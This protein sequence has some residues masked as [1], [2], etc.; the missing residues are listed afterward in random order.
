MECELVYIFPYR[1]FGR[2]GDIS[3]FGERYGSFQEANADGW[4]DRQIWSIV[5]GDEGV[6]TYGPPHHFVNIVG[7]IATKEEHDG[8]TY[9]HEVS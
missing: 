4:S 5:S 6:W 1:Q 8:E 3:E 7:F 9:Y 2:G